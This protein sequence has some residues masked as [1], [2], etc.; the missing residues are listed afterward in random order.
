MAPT[1]GTRLRYK[2]ARSK[3]SQQAKKMPSLKNRIRGLERFLGR[4]GLDD[5]TR[6]IK[7][8]ELERLREEQ[9]HKDHIAVE[10][11]NIEKYKRPRFFERVKV[12]RKLR[13]AKLGIEKAIDDA[14]R[15]EHEKKFKLYQEEMM[16]IYYYPKSEPYIS[17]FPSA[18]HSVANLNRQ[19]EL[20]AEA[21]SLFD[22]EQDR[23]AFHQFCFSEG[24]SKESRSTSEMRSAVELL[25]KKPTKEQVKKK[26]TTRT[27]RDNCGGKAKRTPA[28]VDQDDEDQVSIASD[29]SDVQKDDFFL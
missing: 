7:K 3:K 16:Y 17:L 14:D 12:M 6:R 21:I 4:G 24:K 22:K 11:K 9:A 13:Q 8:V 23:E 28:L 18:P 26:Q 2:N 27:K 1:A 29:A 20:Q 25:L 10:K 19:K 15:G 5:A